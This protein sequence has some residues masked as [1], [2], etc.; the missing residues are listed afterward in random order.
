MAKQT[1]VRDA[2]KWTGIILFGAVGLLLFEWPLTRPWLIG[3]LMVLM[4]L[5]IGKGLYQL[6]RGTRRLDR[7]SV[8]G[9]AVCSGV[10]CLLAD[11]MWDRPI[12]SLVGWLLMIGPFAHSWHE[13]RR[14]S[15]S[16]GTITR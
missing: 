1:K 3:T 4:I 10:I 15:D 8:E 9:L 13:Q 11:M 14:V 7:S 6:T 16:S 12:L 2:L 5:T